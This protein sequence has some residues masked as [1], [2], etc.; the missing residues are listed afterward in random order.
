MSKDEMNTEE[1]EN[2]IELASKTADPSDEIRI[3]RLGSE[4]NTPEHFGE[5]S[6]CLCKTRRCGF[7]IQVESLE[8]GIPRFQRS[9]TAHHA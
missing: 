7:S 6:S 4:V 2:N 9:Q 1:G 8:D 5:Q 3:S